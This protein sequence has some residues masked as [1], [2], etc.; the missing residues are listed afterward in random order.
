MRTQP[1]QGDGADPTRRRG[2]DLVHDRPVPRGGDRQAD[3]ILALDVDHLLN[4]P[5]RLPPAVEE[6]ATGMRRVG[7]LLI[8][9]AKRADVVRATPGDVTIA[10]EQ[11]S[12]HPRI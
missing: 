4:R 5:R 9:V 2:Q 7:A 8:E 3:R 11:Q 1:Y 12:R 6:E 10:P